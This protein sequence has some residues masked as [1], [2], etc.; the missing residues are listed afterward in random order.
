M[1][2]QTDAKIDAC[3][4]L[5]VLR[6]AEHHHGCVLPQCSELSQFFLLLR[7]IYVYYSIDSIDL[8]IMVYH[9]IVYET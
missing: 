2:F 7:Y 6:A 4:R 3:P 8:S 9:Y 1:V 5:H